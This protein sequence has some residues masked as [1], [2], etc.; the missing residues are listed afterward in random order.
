MPKIFPIVV[1][2]TTTT[3]VSSGS[4]TVTYEEAATVDDALNFRVSN[5]EDATVDDSF[6]L[7]TALAEDATVDDALRLTTASSHAE[8]ATVDDTLSLVARLAEDAT[9]D[10]AFALRSSLAE[11]ASVA[12]DLRARFSLT[13]DATVNDLVR[14]VVA[15]L[16]VSRTATPDADFQT[17]AWTDQAATGTNNGNSNLIVKG[18]S[19]LANDER[20]GFLLY[21]LRSFT[22][23]T[24]AGTGLQLTV[25]ASNAGVLT[26]ETV[27]WTASVF[28]AASRPF[29]E[30]ALTWTNQPAT[31]TNSATGTFSV[32]AGGAVN[33]YTITVPPATVNAALGGW[34]MV[35]FTCATAAT[36]NSVTIRSRES[37]PDTT[38]PTT[39]LNHIQRG[40]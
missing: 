4:S 36:P 24:A 19:T 29:T 8:D 25:S 16:F 23:W 17:D 38:K 31:G 10:D 30:S 3:V 6:S 28:A 7:R 26:A 37:T 34:L 13:E 35:A 40:T 2:K 14:L 12:D 15:G 22:S 39:A 21:D 32:P 18:K 27:T 1:K 33:T 9:V 5:P 11:D 20:R